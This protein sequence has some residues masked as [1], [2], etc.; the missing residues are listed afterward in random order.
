MIVLLTNCL[1]IICIFSSLLTHRPHLSQH[2][3]HHSSTVSNPFG[4]RLDI[5]HLQ[6]AVSFYYQTGHIHYKTL[7]CWSAKIHPIL[8]LKQPNCTSNI[9]NPAF[10]R[11][12][13][14]Q[15]NI[16]QSTIKV[17]ISGSAIHNLHMAYGQHQYFANQLT[18][19]LE[20]IFHGTMREQV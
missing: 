4:T 18:L 14:S 5:N 8:H 12:I 1:D 9:T 7:S 3:Y 15:H 10:I 20:Q 17:Y 2:Q 16:T 13:P 19:H 6:A 11:W